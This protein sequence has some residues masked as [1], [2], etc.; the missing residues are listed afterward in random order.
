MS[1]KFLTSVIAIVVLGFFSLVAKADD[2]E[3]AIYTLLGVPDNMAIL[4]VN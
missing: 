2:H 3:P 4:V 1:Q